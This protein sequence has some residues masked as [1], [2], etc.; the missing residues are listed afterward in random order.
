MLPHVS[1]LP[2]PAAGRHADVAAAD[3]LIG[4]PRARMAG[5]VL[6][7]ATRRVDRAAA[8]DVDGLHV[9]EQRA[10]R[11]RLPQQ[12]AAFDGQAVAGDGRRPDGSLDVGVRCGDRRQGRAFAARDVERGRANRIAAPDITAVLQAEDI[13]E[14]D[15][16]PLVA[17]DDGDRLRA[18]RLERDGLRVRRDGVDAPRALQRSGRVFDVDPVAFEVR[19]NVGRA[20]E[21]DRCATRADHAAAAEGRQIRPLGGVAVAVERELAVLLPRTL[22]VERAG[23]AG[24]VR[25]ADAAARD[26]GGQ[27]ARRVV[28]LDRDGAA[29]ALLVIDVAAADFDRAGTADLAG[30]D[31][32]RSA[33]AA[34]IAAVLTVGANHAVERD[35]RRSLDADHAAAGGAGVRTAAVFLRTVDAAE[36]CRGLSERRCADVT[37]GDVLERLLR[38]R[39]A[40]VVLIAA[41]GRVDRAFDG[42]R[43]HVDRQCARRGR[44]P[45]YAAGLDG[46]G[47]AGDRARPQRSANGRRLRDDRRRNRGV[48][49]L[50]EVCGTDRIAALHV[51]VVAHAQRVEHVHAL[52][53]V[54]GGDGDRLGAVRLERDGLAVRRDRVDA[55]HALHGS[56]G[57]LDLDPV[58]F[59]VD[60]NVGGAIER[61]GVAVHADDA[62]RAETR[63]IADLGAVAVAV[64]GDVGVLLRRTFRVERTG[65]AGGG[66]TAG[67]AAQDVPGQTARRVG[68]LDGD[69]AAAGFLVVDIAAASARAS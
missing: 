42:E 37:A 63:Q 1:P 16:L 10:R 69:G 50:V 51:C 28:V 17:G 64:E 39:I 20:I 53:L 67:S 31:P 66:R 12:A 33:G 40:G 22:R 23:A 14:I 43:L 6:I 49:V 47:I 13:Q 46:E 25:T 7:A 29:A 48:A 61:D 27:R 5:V 54:T 26:D 19:R 36:V 34:A 2:P 60:R 18:V 11:I 62:A 15:A 57:V 59:E 24:V 58:A 21:R 30:G 45:Q 32:H 9:E 4:L 55:P 52:P 44:L 68:V 35:R 38:T 41:A 65:A 8:L 3:I 56:G